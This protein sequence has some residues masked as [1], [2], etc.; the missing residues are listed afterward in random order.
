MLIRKMLIHITPR[1]TYPFWHFCLVTT[2]SG[3]VS[4]LTKLNCLSFVCF[5]SRFSCRTSVELTSEFSKKIR[6][7]YSM[8]DDH[9]PWAY[10]NLFA[11]R[12]FL[13]EQSL[14]TVAVLV[15]LFQFSGSS[16]CTLSLWMQNELCH[17]FA[18]IHCTYPLYLTSC[19]SP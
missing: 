9:M 4:R 14:R 7:K 3:Q 10:T 11:G 17:I 12:V 6:F 8:F 19:Y 18:N 2:C 16:F 1:K 13:L 15:S 5:I